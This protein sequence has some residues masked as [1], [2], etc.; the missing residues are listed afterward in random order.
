[1]IN[2]S[3]T[4]AATNIISGLAFGYFGNAIPIIT[5]TGV[6]FL[7]YFWLGSFGVGLLSIG[8]GMLF[9]NN[10]A[11]NTFFVNMENSSLIAV[12]S[13]ATD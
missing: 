11:I 13:Q 1:M 12:Y 2:A 5:L 9:P 3:T 4:G 6:G 8:L 7:A 10:L